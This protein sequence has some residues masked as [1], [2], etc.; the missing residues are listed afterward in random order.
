MY[1]VRYIYMRS[2]NIYT[3]IRMIQVVDI[4]ADVGHERDRPSN[5]RGTKREKTLTLAITPCAGWQRA[6]GTTHL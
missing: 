5:K 4:G 3:H 1:L 6:M 2:G